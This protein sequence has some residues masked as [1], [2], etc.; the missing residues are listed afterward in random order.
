MK[1]KYDALVFDLDGTLLD[2]LR[3]LADSTNA[4]LARHGMPRRTYGEIRGFVG[5]GIRNLLIRAVPG[6]GNHP[7]FEQIY[8]EFCAY[9][10]EHCMDETEPYPGILSLLSELKTRKIRMAIVSNKEDS[11]VKKMSRVYFDGLVDTAVGERT[12][13]RRKPEPDAV[14]QALKEL[15]VPPERAACI[16]DSEVD[17]QTAENAH[18]PCYTVAWGFRSREF[19]LENGADSS[20]MASDAGEL[21]SL[22]TSV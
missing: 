19:L 7:E 1:R 9:Y 13:C 6:G 21:L 3:D 16:G 15:G 20:R 17:I 12:G 10:E 22:L 5:N 8:E 11:A 4:V 2:T 18:L 14:L